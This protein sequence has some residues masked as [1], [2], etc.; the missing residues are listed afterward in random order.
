MRLFKSRKSADYSNVSSVV[1]NENDPHIKIVSCS[2]NHHQT[3]AQN[4]NNNVTHDSKAKIDGTSKSYLANDDQK[5]KNHFDSNNFD[6]IDQCHNTSNHFTYQQHHQNG[7]SIDTSYVDKFTPIPDCDKIIDQPERTKYA[8]NRSIIDDD[9]TAVKNTT[10][11]QHDDPSDF[12]ND[13]FATFDTL[14][15]TS[16]Q[17]KSSIGDD[18]ESSSADTIDEEIESTS[19]MTVDNQ[20]STPDVTKVKLI[21]QNGQLPDYKVVKAVPVII[22]DGETPKESKNMFTWGR[23]MSKKFELLRRNDSRK[24]FESAKSTATDVP[25][26]RSTFSL[27][28]ISRPIL[29]NDENHSTSMNSSFKTFFHRIGSTGMLSRNNQTSSK[30]ITDSRTL[31]RSSSTSQLSTSSYIKGEDPTD[32]VNLCNRTKM[33]GATASTLRENIVTNDGAQ[34]SKKSPIKAAS[35]DD[36]VRA[37]NEPQTP[38]KRGNFPYAF[39]RSRLSVLPE[40]NGG[41]VI[42]HKRVQRAALPQTSEKSATNIEPIKLNE[43]FEDAFDPKGS[44]EHDESSCGCDGGNSE[45]NPQPLT[46]QRLNSCFSSNESGYDSDGRHTE[47][48]NT[49]NSTN[50]KDSLNYIENNGERQKITNNLLPQLPLGA[51]DCTVLR[52]RYKH[53]KLQQINDTDVIGITVTPQYFNLDNV[54][55]CRY[56]VTDLV[57]GGL[58]HI[59]GRIRIGDEIVNVNRIDLRGMQSYDKVEEMLQ[60]FNDNSVELVIA[61]DELTTMC[62]LPENGAKLNG[63]TNSNGINDTDAPI[64]TSNGTIATE[65]S[66]IDETTARQ[67]EMMETADDNAKPKTN[68]GS[69]CRIADMLPLQNFTDYVPVY[70]ERSKIPPTTISDDEKWQI[71]SKKRS[72][73]LSKY[74]YVTPPAFK[75]ISSKKY[76]SIEDLQSNHE[77]IDDKLNETTINPFSLTQNNIKQNRH[78]YCEYK[79]LTQRSADTLKVKFCSPFD[80]TMEYRSIRFNRNTLKHTRQTSTSSV[81]ND[82]ANKCETKKL[83][84]DKIMQKTSKECLADKAPTDLSKYI[85]LKVRFYKGSGMKSLG[86]S[87]VGGRDSPKGNIGIF[88]KTIFASGQ[89]AD[90][91]NLL[92]GDEILSLNNEPLKGMSHLETIAMFKNIK[93]GPVLLHIARRRTTRAKSLDNVQFQVTS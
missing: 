34:L 30:Q 37:S 13:L 33:I 93:E 24:S 39:L 36:I 45:R 68:N 86:F 67:S 12:I 81:G 15:P 6:R 54:L 17:T 8:Q 46:Y 52:R 84:D 11:I 20:P 51:T 19:N 18:T 41:S 22:L 74:G 40:E 53:I 55:E 70:S 60:T 82:Q 21:G 47:E 77:I 62:D 80:A 85:F 16:L 87:I 1:A 71:L 3:N 26:E 32:G 72:E 73:F 28:R 50:S 65:I 90:D 66:T 78:S 83:A 35:Y 42:N 49:T 7:K 88:V 91:G 57:N 76:L 75:D 14:E 59:D 38:T 63:D 48:Q 10:T 44:T 69:C 56:I 43:T 64:N 31:Y 58:A 89:A 27:K 23:R 79:P 61:H 29:L 9:L 25:S 2:T 5:T 92:A 4:N